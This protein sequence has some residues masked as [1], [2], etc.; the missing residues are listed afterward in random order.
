MQTATDERLKIN[1]N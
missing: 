1:T